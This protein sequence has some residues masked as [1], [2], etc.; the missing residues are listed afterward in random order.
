VDRVTVD[1]AEPWAMLDPIATALRPGG[2]LTCFV[3]TILQVKSLVD[4]LDAHASF[5]MVTTLESLLRHWEVKGRSIRPA[6]R[7]VAHTGLLVF[8]R[9]L[10][11]DVAVELTPADPYTIEVALDVAATESVFDDESGD[12]GTD[13]ESD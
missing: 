12:S 8:A 2:V 1:L 5:G 13:L 7:M 9:R 6:H 4:A 3:P 11:T 10:A